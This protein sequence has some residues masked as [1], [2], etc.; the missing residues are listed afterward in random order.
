[1]RKFYPQVEVV[2]MADKSKRFESP[3]LLVIAFLLFACIWLEWYFHFVLGVEVVYP[4]LFYIPIVLAGVFWG[5][6]GGLLVSLFLA[7]LHLGSYLPEI[8]LAVLSRSF[9]FILV[10]CFVG[11]LSDQRKSGE[12]LLEKSEEKY[13]DLY[14]NAPDMYHSL[15]GN[16]IIIECNETEAKKLGYKKEE[17]I[18]RPLT[19]FL[20]ENS[21]KLFHESFAKLKKEKVLL[22]LEREFIRKDGTIFPASLNT[23]TNFDEKE[24]MIRT[25]TIARD[26]TELSR[27]EEALRESE[28]R[29]RTTLNSMGDAIHVVDAEL[30][31]IL[32]NTTFGKWCES[33]GLFDP[34]TEAVDRTIFELFPFLPERVRDEYKEVFATGKVLITEE[35]NKV[36]DRKIITET[37][38]IPILEKNKVVSVITSIRDITERKRTEE[39][40]DKLLKAISNSNEGIAI[41]DEKDRYI[42]VNSAHAKIYGYSQ[43]ELIGKNWKDITPPEIVSAREKSVTDTL[44]DKNVGIFVGEVPALRKDGTT[45]PTKVSGTAI[46]DEKLDYRGHICVVTDISEHKS[47]QE[48]LFQAQK[49]ETIGRFAGGIAHDFNNLLTAIRGNAELLQQALSP[50]KPEKELVEEILETSDRAANLTNQLLIFSHRKP[51]ELTIL[52]IN[53]V[54]SNLRNTIQRLIGEDIELV[55]LLGE[56]VGLVKTDSGQ[57]EQVLFN[58]VL[59]ARDAMPKGG[60]L[61]I[62]TVNTCLDETYANEHLGVTPG[63]YVLISV[64][65]AGVGMSEDE[66]P[67]IFEPFFTTKEV[68]KGTGLG[69]SVVYGIV[70]QNNGHITVYSELGKGTTFHIYLPHID[71]EKDSSLHKTEKF[72]Y[73]PK[74]KETILVVEDDLSVKKFTSR[75][76]GNLGYVVLEASK[77][78]EALKALEEEKN[79]KVDLLLTDVVMPQMSGKELAK[80]IKISYPEMKVIFM[81]G[82]TFSHLA[83]HEIQENEVHFIQKPFTIEILAKK[84]REVLE[85]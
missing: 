83:S 38:K 32:F 44:H 74:G 9:I 28:L 14:E 50:Q 78:E 17:I 18:G 48:Q 76:L 24:R 73:L 52:Q 70:K 45:I 54:I 60:R 62:E 58:L 53:E 55:F 66:L 40:K 2:K 33:L 23:F 85:K 47:L 41:T 3:W 31:V 11:K 8:K 69:L 30:R 68:G 72:S 27:T 61:V 35:P 13:R 42:Y 12:E 81:S 63:D 79:L 71:E 36:G 56:D 25:K 46:W 15:D 82:Y 5:L 80:K 22:N 37:R 59:N 77:P 65:D 57:M 39:E 6:Q 20:T 43:E 16:G 26:I 67:H 34:E 84:V 7:F 51:I 75:A 49:M 21:K 29:Y 64:T 10:G 19:D 4:H 1:M